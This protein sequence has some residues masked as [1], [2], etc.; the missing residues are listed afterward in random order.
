M[1]NLFNVAV[2]FGSA[3]LTIW[4]MVYG[5]GVTAKSWPIIVVAVILQFLLVCVHANVNNSN[6]SVQSQPAS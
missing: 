5:W 6:R 4:A 2:F 3:L 1:K